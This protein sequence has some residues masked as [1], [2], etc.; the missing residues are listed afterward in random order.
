M[1][2]GHTVEQVIELE[3]TE[4]M[5]QPQ[6]HAYWQFLF[7]ASNTDHLDSSKIYQKPILDANGNPTEEMT[8]L[9]V[10]KEV[11]RYANKRGE[12]RFL[13]KGEK[14]GNGGYGT[15]YKALGKIKLTD[16]DGVLSYQDY[17]NNLKYV[18]KEQIHDE[19]HPIE[20]AEQE[21]MMSAKLFDLRGKNPVFSHDQKRSFIIQRY[22]PGKDLRVIIWEESFR[23]SMNS[24]DRLRL[25]RSLFKSYKEQMMDPKIVNRDVK[26]ENTMV[27]SSGKNVFIDPGHAFDAAMATVTQQCGGTPLYYAPEYWRGRI[28]SNATDT[29]G[30]GVSLF[31]LWNKEKLISERVEADFNTAIQALNTYH[32]HLKVRSKESKFFYGI[33]CKNIAATSTATI[34]KDELLQLIADLAKS[35]NNVVLSMRRSKILTILNELKFGAME[36][37][38]H[39][40]NEEQIMSPNDM[41][42]GQ[43][44]TL[45]MIL[46]RT[47]SPDPNLRSVVS[48]ITEVDQLLFQRKLSRTKASRHAALTTA[49]TKATEMKIHIN[50]YCTESVVN[51]TREQGEAIKTNANRLLD[52]VQDTPSAIGQFV[53]TLDIDAITQA[54]HNTR[55]IAKQ[56]IATAIDTFFSLASIFSKIHHDIQEKKSEINPSVL[57]TKIEDRIMGFVK[58]YGHFSFTFDR[59]VFIT[60]KLEKELSHLQPMYLQFL[61]QVSASVCDTSSN[62]YPSTPPH[63]SFESENGNANLT[64]PK[65][66]PQTSP[67]VLGQKRRMSNN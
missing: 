47:T 64:S 33:L 51:L 24:D 67:S 44:A 9:R 18:I 32:D 45:K 17:T 27:N 58:S 40:Y 20:N 43:Q 3:P 23:P 15:V 22:I 59:M 57:G 19:L 12:P 31:Q 63:Q 1:L 49:F 38:A 26:P 7:S 2:S 42:A 54:P 55:E 10:T 4:I 25:T 36:D 5:N 11:I 34:K 65:K 61:Q 28:A 6:Y 66:S 46:E 8:K 16:F 39:R 37:R 52:E 62:F 48:G 41:D 21:A 30:L 50:Q 13:I 53:E 60:K 56:Y 35:P 29:F 14:L